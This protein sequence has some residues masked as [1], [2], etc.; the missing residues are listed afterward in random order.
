M[1]DPNDD[2]EQRVLSCL[3]GIFPELEPAALAQLSQDACA[4]WDSVAH[5]TMYAALGEAFAIELDFEAFAQ[6]TSFA[7]V[8]AQVKAQLGR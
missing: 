7:R 4:A 3:A 2:I 6:A 1:D 5:V 8:V